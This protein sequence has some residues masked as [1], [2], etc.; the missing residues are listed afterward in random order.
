MYPLFFAN[1]FIIKRIGLS[2]D[3][4]R[5]CVAAERQMQPEAN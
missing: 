5:F 3:K 4:F 1:Q 2:Y